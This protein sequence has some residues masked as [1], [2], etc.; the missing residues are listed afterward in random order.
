[1]EYLMTKSIQPTAPVLYLPHP[2]SGVY[3]NA[4]LSAYAMQGVGGFTTFLGLSLLTPTDNYLAPF[5]TAVGLSFAFLGCELYK[6]ATNVESFHNKNSNTLDKLVNLTTKVDTK[7]AL[8]A[9]TEKLFLQ[10]VYRDLVIAE[11]EIFNKVEVY[12][13][14]RAS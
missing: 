1:M 13:L 4:R 9:A 11:G 10:N 2:S 12:L 14:P 6:G 5:I 7:K 3:A 8:E